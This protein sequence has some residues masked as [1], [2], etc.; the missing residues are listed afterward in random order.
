M[1]EK[2]TYEWVTPNTRAFLGEGVLQ[3]NQSVDDKLDL[4]AY[5][6]E[7][8]LGIKGFSKRVIRAFKN[9]EISPSSPMWSSF[10]E[11]SGYD[12]SCFGSYISDSIRSIMEK[13]TEVAVMSKGGGGTSGY[14]G[15]IRPRGA[16]FGENGTSMGPMNF[17][18]LYEVV[19]DTISQGAVRRG[20]FAAYLDFSHPDV[21]EFLQMRSEG[22][23]IQNINF[24]L[25]ITNED[26]KNIFERG[27]E[28]D[29]KVWARML[30][31]QFETGYPYVFFVDNA[32][33]Q[34]PQVYKDK[35][36][37]IAHSNLC[38]EI[39]LPNSEDESFVC[40]LASLNLEK[41]DD[42][43]QNDTVETCVFLLDA[44]MSEFIQKTEGVTHMEAARKFAIRHR[45]LGMGAMGWH[46]YLQDRL[47]PYESLEAKMIN[48]NIWRTIRER[49]DNATEQLAEIYG[50][51]EI[52]TGYGRRNTTTLAV[53]PTIS[54]SFILGG[55]S[56]S[57]EPWTA[58]YFVEDLAKG[59]FTIKNKQLERLLEEYGRN[60]KAVWRSILDHGGSVQH[61]DW[62]SE[63][64]RNIFKTFEE[65]SQKEVVIQAAQRQK[66]IDQ[67]QS[68]N[69]RIHPATPAKD[70]SELIKFAWEQGIK[71]LY[72]QRGVN[73]VQEKARNI[74][75]CV[76]CE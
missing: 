3:K 62:L 13:A 22:H 58:N 30:Q 26:M 67:G 50:E 12:I 74:N 2:N 64:H 44:V 20:A 59:R 27:V 63:E 76:S 68:L 75:H 6:A 17:M 7:D 36:M 15:E 48:N 39:M 24:G 32:N 71:S 53:A 55:V 52:L 9:K 19:A 35:G 14:F 37:Y 61:I 23:P 38:S 29:Q 54:S 18:K 4:I 51:P 11:E 46:T 57:V 69:R 70:V 47:I 73:L 40:C 72:Y 65:I 60:T 10:G 8:I 21:L 43:E 5:R 25:C 34:K 16:K 66:Y 42:I 49:A 56:P 28:R 33:D 41:W 1:R 45:A 31:C